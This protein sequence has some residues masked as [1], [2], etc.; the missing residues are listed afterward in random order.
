[1]TDVLEPTYLEIADLN[2][3]T[4]IATLKTLSDSDL[5]LLLQTA[6]DQIDAYVGPQRHHPTTRTRTESSR[7]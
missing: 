5:T 4:T 3:Q 6:E 7:G 1:M 2:A